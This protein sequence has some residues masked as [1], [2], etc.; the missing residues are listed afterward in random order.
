MD[1]TSRVTNGILV[2]AVTIKTIED[3]FKTEYNYQNCVFNLLMDIHC[4]LTHIVYHNNL[5]YN[6]LDVLSVM[7]SMFQVMDFTP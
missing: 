7:R 6:E 5:L 3:Y 2:P 1:E 4:M